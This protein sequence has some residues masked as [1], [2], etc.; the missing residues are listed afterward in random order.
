MCPGGG[1]VFGQSGSPF[2]SEGFGGGMSM[3]MGGPGAIKTPSYKD[4]G[5]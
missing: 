1:S 2:G 4:E 5:Y 3:G